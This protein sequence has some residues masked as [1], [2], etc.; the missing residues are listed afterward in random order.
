[1]ITYTQRLNALTRPTTW[2]V[3]EKGLFWNE[4][5][6]KS[7]EIP[8]SKVRNVR[9]RFE[10]TRFETRR[11]TLHFQA[12]Y[13]FQISNI[14]YQGIGNFKPQPDEFRAFVEGFHKFIPRTAGI[15]FRVGS[16]WPAYVMNVV[17]T[18]GVVTLLLALAPIAQATGMPGGIVL[19]RIVLI[20]IFLPV[21]FKFLWL[22]RPRSYDPDHLPQK[23]LDQ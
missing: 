7:G 3:S 18:I 4:E 8:W 9:L 5:G 13:P 11:V 2:R 15:R 21:L 14:E 22:N 16:T 19:T 23:M 6:G 1:M 20:L 10:P 12:P 17:I